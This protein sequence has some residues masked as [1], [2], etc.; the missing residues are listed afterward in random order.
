MD[1]YSHCFYY[2]ASSTRIAVRTGV[3]GTLN[4]LL[5]DH[6]GSQA[7]TTNSSGT[8]TGEIRYF[9]WG[10]ER[11][12]Y[13]A[14]PTTY[15]FTGQRLESSLGLYYYGARWY[16]PAVGRFT[17]PDTLIPEQQGV[18]AW[19][20]YAYTNNNPVKYTDPNGNMVDDGCQLGECAGN[21]VPDGI[22]QEQHER[23]MFLNILSKSLS[24]RMKNGEITDV[25]ALAL[26]LDISAKRYGN[27]VDSY[28]TDIG[29]V[30][31]GLDTTDIIPKAI[32]SNNSLNIYYVGYSAFDP[33][34]TGF[35]T[36]LNPNNDNQVRH[37]IAGASASNH[38]GMLAETR[39]LLSEQ[40]GSEDYK[41]YQMSF[42]FVDTL[43]GTNYG[44]VQGPNHIYLPGDWV[45]E[46]LAK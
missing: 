12:T 34:I 40:L 32:D 45:R 6:L 18:Q 19:D 9:P 21:T 36:E 42:E 3:N 28:L 26:L 1:N 10:T 46:N 41:L 5:G 39:L 35:K 15:H 17:S 38:L 33:E 44:K 22:T 16:D 30:V 43:R 31:G 25:E 4:F 8:R 7:I 20:R 13:G 29:I 37:F 24:K 11:Y 27:D 14:T 23:L 2:Y